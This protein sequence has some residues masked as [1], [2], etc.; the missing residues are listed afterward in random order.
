MGAVQPRRLGTRARQLPPGR[1]RRVA[2]PARRSAQRPVGGIVMEGARPRVGIVFGGGDDA[3]TAAVAA[4]TFT[5][6]LLRRLP[7]ARIEVLTTGAAAGASPLDCGRPVRQLAAGGADRQRLDGLVVIGD[8]KVPAR[9]GA[10]ACPLVRLPGSALDV[11]Q[12]AVAAARGDLLT[13]RVGL[14]RLLGWLPADGTPHVMMD[15]DSG[16]LAVIA[17]A[18][19]ATGSVG[20]GLPPEAGVD[21]IIAAVASASAYRGSDPLLAAIAGGVGGGHAVSVDGIDG[22]LDSAATSA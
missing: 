7:G 1:R 10:G 12:L 17:R 2:G 9:A 22:A 8:A 3:L 20:M 18:T 5:V 6:A 19:D 4:R 15:A 16:S 13:N 11:A 14:L 21:E